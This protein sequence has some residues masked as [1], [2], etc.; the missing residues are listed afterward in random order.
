[1][2]AAGTLIVLLDS[3]A[4]EVVVLDG[5]LGSDGTDPATISGLAATSRDTL[6]VIDD[7]S[8]QNDLTPIFSRRAALVRSSV[9]YPAL[10]GLMVARALDQHFGGNGSLNRFLTE[11]DLRVH[12][13]VRKL[14][15]QIDSRN[16]FRETELDPVARY[17]G[18]G[19]GTGDFMAGSDVDTAEYGEVAMEVVVEVMGASERVLRLTLK[20]FDGTTETRDVV[21]PAGAAAGT[22]FPVGA[23]GDRF[24]GVA[25]IV[26][27][28]VGGNA[29][30]RIRV[31]SIVERVI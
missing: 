6:A 7:A 28:G 19:A 13:N 29:G 16:V 20:N 30:D 11:N 27:V 8:I 24:V 21:L 3:L 5:A 22:A 12:P 31:R 26:T 10:N 23:A 15:V 4:R 17:E 9:L 2:L 18:S 1:M 14:G 25:G